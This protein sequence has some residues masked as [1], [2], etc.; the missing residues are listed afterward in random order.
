MNA[1]IVHAH[2]N[3]DSFCSALAFS[4]K[5]KL[6]EQGYQVEISDLYAK[7]FNPVGGKHDFE[8]LST[9]S[10]YKY[11]SEQIHAS[12][13]DGF[14]PELKKE[15]ELLLS[16]DVLIFNFPL[17]WFGMPAVLKGWVDRVLAYGFAYGGDYGFFDKGR[18]R[19]KK[20]FLCVTTG[21]PADFYTETGAHGRTVSDILKNIHQG[22]L[23]LIGF[24]VLPD[25]VGYGASRISQEERAAILEDYRSYLGQHL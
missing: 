13:N 24:D 4:A 16:A 6:E 9:A 12:K 1:L 7:R 17:W 19:G 22:I 20:A 11:A 2:E 8:A 14:T 15:M 23:A 5:K 10:Y 18:F 3:P 25:F 21:S